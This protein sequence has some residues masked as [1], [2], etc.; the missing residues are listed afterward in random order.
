MKIIYFT[1]ACQKE[2]YVSLSSAWR[3]S[4]N[5]SIQNL[6]NRLIRSLALTHEVE[7]IS[8]RP[9][10]RR[11]CTLRKL[12]AESKQ[13]GKIIWHYLPVKRPRTIR[14]VSMRIQ[15]KKLMSK[16]NLKDAIILT[17]T[18]N[19]NVIKCSTQLARKHSLPIIGVCHNTPSGIRNTGRSYTTYLLNKAEDL[20]GFI[21]STYELNDLFNKGHRAYLTF[22]GILENKY[23]E[24]DCSKYGKYFYYDGNLDEKFGIYDLIEAF[25]SL[26]LEDIKLLISGYHVKEEKLSEAIENNSNIIYLGKQN[27]DTV[28]S[29][30]N[31]AIININ[32]RPYSED[33]DR[34]LIPDNLIDYL[35]SDNALIVSVKNHRLNKDFSDNV[36]WVNSS[37]IDDL[38]KGIQDCLNLDSNQRDIMVRRAKTDANRL[39]SMSAINKKTIA[40]LRLFL[41]QK[42]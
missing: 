34:Y 31:N 25:K 40:F 27:V 22:S 39:F 18:L 3:C 26:N 38:V 17:E 42:E 29:L 9:F 15:A 37:D 21:A 6:H 35:D 16:M 8:F 7:V 41:K 33:Y 23:Q 2:D 4:L 36:I 19:P 20:S 13:E 28:L 1:T 11:F 14:F 32:P 12:E 10:S 30:I 24:V 5:T